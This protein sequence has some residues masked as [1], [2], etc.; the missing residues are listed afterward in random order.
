M[1]NLLGNAIPVGVKAEEKV[2]VFRENGVACV[3][4]DIVYV[5]DNDPSTGDI[6]ACIENV[7]KDD[8]G[9]DC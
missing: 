2:T 4:A 1:D 5:D 8:G 7:A 6:D 9:S 3:E